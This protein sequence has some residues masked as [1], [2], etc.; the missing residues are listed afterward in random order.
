MQNNMAIHV[1]TK[2]IQPATSNQQPVTSNQQPATSNQQPHPSAPTLNIQHG[3]AAHIHAMIPRAYA[4]RGM[5]LCVRVAAAPS[6]KCGAGEWLAP[7]P[8]SVWSPPTPPGWPSPALSS[9]GGRLVALPS[10]HSTVLG[11]CA[12]ALS[13]G[14]SEARPDARA[15]DH[16]HTYKRTNCLHT[17]GRAESL[18][19]AYSRLGGRLLRCP[20]PLT[21]FQRIPVVPSH[22]MEPRTQSP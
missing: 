5:P 10:T 17:R 11:Q 19:R 3:F 16:I 1:N 18:A 15:S 20:R 4:P 14:P 21:S 12:P 2:T 6:L 8:S 7:A 13:G 22:S 9:R